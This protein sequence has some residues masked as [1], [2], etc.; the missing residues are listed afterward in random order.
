[1]TDIL[2][3]YGTSNQALTIT[4]A[5]LANNGQRESTV[6]DNSSNKYLDAL[7]SVKVKTGAGTPGTG[8]VV[9]VYA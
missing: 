9:N 3:K 6:I 4:L 5:S 1:M 8:P 7:V 2:A